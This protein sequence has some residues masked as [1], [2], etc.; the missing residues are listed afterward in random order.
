MEDHYARWEFFT[1]EELLTLE[2]GLW[3][4]D[5]EGQ[6]DHE[7]MALADEIRQVILTR[8]E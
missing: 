2:R 4:L 6:A 8:Q 3:V 1:T 5:H 7:A